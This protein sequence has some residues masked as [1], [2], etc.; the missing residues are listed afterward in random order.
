MNTSKDHDD[1]PANEPLLLTLDTAKDGDTISPTRSHSPKESNASLSDP[2]QDDDF[3]TDTPPTR[4]HRRSA[5][6]PSFRRL[7]QVNEI[8][9]EKGPEIKDGSPIPVPTDRSAS[10][11]TLSSDT[12]FQRLMAEL[13]LESSSPKIVFDNAV[14]HVSSWRE[15]V[16]LPQLDE[17]HPMDDY[18]V[19]LLRRERIHARNVTLIADNS[20]THMLH[21]SFRSLMTAKRIED[22][23]ESSEVEDPSESSLNFEGLAS[24]QVLSQSPDYGSIMS[25]ARL[26]SI[27]RRLNHKK[28]KPTD[29]IGPAVA[30]ATPDI[31]F[32]RESYESQDISKLMLSPMKE[33]SPNSVMDVLGAAGLG[34]SSN[35]ADKKK[36]IKIIDAEILGLKTDETL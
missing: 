1:P 18:M 29:S 30:A 8:V 16:L 25:I 2:Y 19:Y 6:V 17:Y 36:A 24:G 35:A 15:S 5:S 21:S 34:P 14:L 20:K 11:D 31:T 12:Y 7:A 13:K 9:G 26:P 23:T 32:S 33:E 22:E 4:F 10:S 3:P 28:L 27:Q